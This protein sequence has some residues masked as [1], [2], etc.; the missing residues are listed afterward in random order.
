[1][2]RLPTFAI[3][4]AFGSIL[5]WPG[6][7]LAS[8]TASV[9]PVGANDLAHNDGSNGAFAIAHDLA[10]GS[11]GGPRTL[12]TNESSGQRREDRTGE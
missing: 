10:W 12:A 2:K 8:Q 11:T 9:I 7:R 4:L 3:L 1:M 6:G 5:C